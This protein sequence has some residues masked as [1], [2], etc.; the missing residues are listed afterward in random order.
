RS[1]A[2]PYCRSLSA[3]SSSSTVANSSR[4]THHP[5]VTTCIGGGAGTRTLDGVPYRVKPGTRDGRGGRGGL[6]C[7]MAGFLLNADRAL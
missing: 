4:S 2:L 3:A 5:L 7:G 1:G 6:G